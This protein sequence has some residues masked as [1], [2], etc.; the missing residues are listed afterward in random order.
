MKYFET[1]IFAKRIGS[2]VR[3]LGLTCHGFGPVFSQP[4]LW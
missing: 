1:R 3:D 2:A 4:V